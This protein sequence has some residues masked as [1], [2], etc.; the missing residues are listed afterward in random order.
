MPFNSVNTRICIV[1]CFIEVDLLM[2]LFNWRYVWLCGSYAQ[3]RPNVDNN[4]SKGEPY[5]H[6]VMQTVKQQSL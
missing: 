5:C 1:V 2:H 6:K 3:L 4:F